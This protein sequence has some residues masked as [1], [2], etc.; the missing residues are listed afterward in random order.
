M[1]SHLLFMTWVYFI[2]YECL[3]WDIG[4]KQG[5]EAFCGTDIESHTERSLIAAET[6]IITSFGCYLITEPLTYTGLITYV[7]RSASTN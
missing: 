3:Q 2:V 6:H 5:L 1:Q 4:V 7:Y